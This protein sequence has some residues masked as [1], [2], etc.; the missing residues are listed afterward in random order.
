MNRA[1]IKWTSIIAGLLLFGFGCYFI[2]ECIH[3]I[4]V[5]I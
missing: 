4:K 1:M 5:L 2:Y 3:D